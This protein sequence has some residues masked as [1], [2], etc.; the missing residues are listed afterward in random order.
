MENFPPW[1]LH[2]ANHSNFKKTFLFHL[3]VWEALHLCQCPPC[4][5]RFPKAVLASRRLVAPSP[6]PLGLRSSTRRGSGAQIGWFDSSDSL[7]VSRNLQKNW[8]AFFV[9]FADWGVQSPC[10]MIGGV[11]LSPPQPRIYIDSFPLPPSWSIMEVSDDPGNWIYK[12]HFGIFWVW[13]PA[14]KSRFI[15]VPY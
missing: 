13:L 9:V 6:E 5:H 11:Q 15:R 4:Y 14:G 3:H 12:L 2:M 8:P 10:Q 7:G 1:N